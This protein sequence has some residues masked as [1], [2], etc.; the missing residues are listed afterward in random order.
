M[1]IAFDL[2]RIENPGIGRYMKCL[3]E[4][5]LRRETEHD[6]LLILAPKARDAIRSN[7]TRVERVHASSHYYS[8]R[9]QIEIPR[10]LRENKVD[11]LH[12]PHFLL[13]LSRPCP[14]VVTIH[15]VVYI[16]CAEDLPSHLGQFYY[17]AMMRASA[18]LATRII[19]DSVF[20]KNEIIRYLHVDPDKIA[21]IYPAVD[22]TFGRI[23]DPATLQ[24]AR[25]D[26]SIH[27]DY[28][29]YTGIY[30]GRKNHA[31]LLKA[32]Q[33]FLA[34]G[35][36]AQLVIAGPMY[37]GEASL[38]SLAAELG[39]AQQVVF[40]G[41]VADS[42]LNALYSGARVYACP[43]LY[44]GFGFT[45]LEAMACG[46]PVVCSEAASLPEVAGDAALYADARNPESFADALYQVFT[47]QGLRQE[48]MKRGEENL[49]R[50]GWEQAATRCL[51]T[52]DEVIGS[53]IRRAIAFA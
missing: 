2:R 53:T 1:K 49:R 42:N 25:A 30:K 32:F 22:A 39:I 18:R 24:A 51:K 17:S 13:P 11:L 52:Y 45:V 46:T 16:A 41:F 14:A 50:F 36:R 19:T 20:S 10:I 26:Y 37:E 12:A 5:I 43:S 47:K 38:R 4:E 40:T 34:Q 8:V 21:V 33:R 44:E 29:L 9:E 48:M 27:D 31:G 35:T 3:V 6:Y 15:D 23:S 28:I 7:S